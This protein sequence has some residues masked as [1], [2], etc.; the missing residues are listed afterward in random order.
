MGLG[1]NFEAFLSPSL[2]ALFVSN[3]GNDT[4]SEYALTGSDTITTINLLGGSHPVALSSTQSGVMYV[5]NSG[6]NSMCPK[7]GSI[8]TINTATLAASNTACL[9]FALPPP[10]G[11]AYGV[12]P[13]AM[14]Q[15]TGGGRIFIIS[16]FDNSV[17]VYDPPTQTIVARFTTPKNGLGLNAINLAASA[18]GF[19]IFVVTAG[20]GASPGAL[21]I[22]AT[23]TVTTS[24]LVV[25]P[26]VP[27]GVRPNFAFVDPNLDRLYVTNSGS[28]TVSVFDASN[29]NVSGSPAIPLLGT[30]NVGT[31]PVSL[32]ALPN[33]TKFY[34]ANSGSNNVTDVSATSFAALGTIPLPSGANPVWI[35]SEPTSSKVYV[36]NQ[37]ASSTTII[38]T[39]NDAIAASIPA[40]AQDPNCTSSCALQQPVMIITQ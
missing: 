26:S 1:S 5:L 28:N 24:D 4:V 11:F 17:W 12:N 31:T 2:G 40:P 3:G 8:S 20:D 33:G 13:I 29:V 35:A 21:D 9:V 18:D 39:S 27:L 36:A 30:A 34:V 25:L 16:Q 14:V 23:S 7:S 19:Y 37:S 15:A 22:I 38:Q 32:T 10:L 6:A